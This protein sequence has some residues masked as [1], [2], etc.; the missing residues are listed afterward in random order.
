MKVLIVSHSC[1]VKENQKKIEA[2][3]A[4]K[5][6]QITLLIPSEWRETLRDIQ[7]E[8]T[9]D[10]NYRII[11]S[12][13]FFNGHTGGFLFPPVLVRKLLKEGFDIIHLEEEP[14]SAVAF[15][16]TLFNNLI[17]KSKVVIFTWENLFV[18]RKFPRSLLESYVL[19][20][21]DRLIAGNSDGRAVMEKK[22]FRGPVDIVPLMGVD[23][24]FF[25]SR[26]E[27]RLKE[28]LG[29][30]GNFVVGYIGRLVPDK[31][32]ANLVDAVN[33]VGGDVRCLLIGRG[34]FKE[35]L[36]GRIQAAG[37]TE[38]FVFIDTVL[39]H[40][41]PQYLNVMDCLVLPSLTTPSWK[42]QFGH[43]LIEA[44][45]SGVPVAGSD[46]GAIPEVIGDAGLIFREGDT[47]GLTECIKR[48]MENGELRSGYSKKGRTRVLEQY[49]HEKIAGRT[50]SIW[51]SMLK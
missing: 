39:H 34:K 47:E 41:V 27:N 37:K 13:V 14:H 16:F 9:S 19:K 3:A 8:K 20:S 6:A 38:R 48:L 33:S 11:T 18:E 32:L 7:A 28:S 10:D 2:L 45:S 24:E 30:S 17:S 42:E 36:T 21:A 29:L 49:S 46:S 23:T 25:K 5:E 22:G 40:E 1:V 43:V 15:Q 35:E 44:M 4:L 12:K 26:E 50:V 31:G 51:K